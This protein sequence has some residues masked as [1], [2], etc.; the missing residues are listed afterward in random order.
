MAPRLRECEELALRQGATNADCGEF[1]N[2]LQK[3]GGQ[4]DA[5][6]ML[7]DVQAIL[8]G[9]LVLALEE[10]EPQPIPVNLVHAG[11]RLLPAKLRAFLDFAAPRLKE[12][13]AR[14]ALV[15]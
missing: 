10:F 13:V 15:G 12:R 5:H 3:C 1:D 7:T 4:T 9:A 14:S 2:G 8:A 6:E 11:Q